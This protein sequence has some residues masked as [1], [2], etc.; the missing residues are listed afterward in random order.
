[1]QSLGRAFFVLFGGVGL[2]LLGGTLT[3]FLYNRAQW[4]GWPHVDA[5]VVDYEVEIADPSMNRPVYVFQLH[6]RPVRAHPSAFTDAPQDPP[7]G[8]HVPLAVNPSN[9]LDF[10]TQPQF[11]FAYLVLILIGSV[12]L[13]LGGL[14]LWASFRGEPAPVALAE[15][16]TSGAWELPMPGALKPLVWLIGG[17]GQAFVRARYA[18]AAS[19]VLAVMGLRARSDGDA[20]QTVRNW[21]VLASLSAGA[22]V[23]L[24]LMAGRGEPPVDP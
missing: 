6:G 23:V 20:P 3:H 17:S 8:G 21:W 15:G 11:Y 4:R 1:M 19:I 10:A 14:F 9:P 2:L 7:A 12:F 22:W 18:L 13:L 16:R 5:T 24:R